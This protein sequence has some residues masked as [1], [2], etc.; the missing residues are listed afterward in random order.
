MYV[1]EHK[2]RKNRG[3]EEQE[4]CKEAGR[5]ST[6]SGETRPERSPDQV[7][8]VE[9]MTASYMDKNFTQLIEQ[10]KGPDI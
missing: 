5:E 9:I 8:P 2:G 4:K 6:L 7:R 10:E 3:K 1:K